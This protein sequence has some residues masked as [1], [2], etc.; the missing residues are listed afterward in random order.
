[1]LK[2]RDGQGLSI[3]III[4]A[5]IGLIILIVM[6]MIFSSQSSKNVDTLES[7]FVKGGECKTPDLCRGEIVPATCPSTQKCCVTI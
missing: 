7:C 5:V 3:R 4:L 6:M 2:K 1:M